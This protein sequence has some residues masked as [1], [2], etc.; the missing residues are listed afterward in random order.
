MEPRFPF[1]IPNGWYLMAYSDEVA[2]GQVLPLH[3]FER[4]FVAFRGESGSVAVFDA[5]C[6]HLGAHLGH[7]GR[8][9]GDSLRCPFHGWRWDLD[10]VLVELPAEWDFPQVFGHPI[11]ASRRRRWPNGVA[12][13]S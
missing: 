13:S 12:S 5:F 10:G 1:G 3:Y 6:P 9:V 4:D 11:R 2:A 8:V 7:G